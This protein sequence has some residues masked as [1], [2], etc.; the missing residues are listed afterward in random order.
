[1]SLMGAV[2]PLASALAMAPMGRIAGS[3]SAVIGTL[4]F[5][6]G[7]VVGVMLGALG[8]ASAWPMASCWR[9]PASAGCCCTCCCGARFA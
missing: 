9:S 7:A 5:G 1:M 3:A 8:R 4:Q 6:G 2:L